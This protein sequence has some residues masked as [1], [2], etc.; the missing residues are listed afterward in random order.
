ME[1]IS[2]TERAGTLSPQS[3]EALLRVAASA[4]E[5]ELE[6]RGPLEIDLSRYAPELQAAGASFVT[7]RADDGELL[8]CIGTMQA[9]EPLVA[10]VAKNAVAA[11][12]QD[13]RF[14]SNHL[15]SLGGV[16]IHISVLSPLE[17]VQVASEAELLACVRPGIDGLLIEDGVF[18][19]T[20]LPAVWENLPDPVEF[21]AHLKDKAGLPIDYWSRTMKVYRYTAESI[22]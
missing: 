14:A 18:R 8:G 2:S 13:P 9:R 15:T 20:F 10:N 5:H 3:R 17:P 21:L 7:L 19:G 4:I 11:A 1:P 22:P 12:F 6:H 16:D